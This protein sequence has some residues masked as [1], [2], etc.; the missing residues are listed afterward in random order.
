M[1]SIVDLDQTPHSV[2]SD[3]GLHCLLGTVCLGGTDCLK[4]VELVE[5]K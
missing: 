3:L 1:T 4:K 5:S 2:A